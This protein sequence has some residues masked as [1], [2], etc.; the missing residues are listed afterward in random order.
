MF[1]SQEQTGGSVGL[2]FGFW[3][4]GRFEVR[5]FQVQ[6]NTSARTCIWDIRGY[7]KIL[8]HSRM[9]CVSFKSQNIVRIWKYFSSSEQKFRKYHHFFHLPHLLLVTT[10]TTPISN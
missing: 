5:Y 9:F 8:S 3:R 7:D 4:F 2:R 6:P 10:L 1:G